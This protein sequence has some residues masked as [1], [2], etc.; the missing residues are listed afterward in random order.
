VWVKL[1]E[2]G[3][4]NGVWAVDTLITNRGKHSVTLPKLTPGEYLLRPEII[5]LHEGNRVG[6]AQFYMECVQ[7]KVTGSGSVSLPAGV[8]I[9]GTYTAQDPGVLFDIYNSFSSYPIPGPKVW[10]G[11]SGSGAAPAPV[12]SKA[13]APA[14]SVAAVATSAPA[15]TPKPVTSAPAAAPKPTTFVTLVKSVTRT[16]APAATAPAGNT[17]GA[18]EKY[19]RCGGQGYTGSTI[20]ADGWTCKVQNPWYSQCLSA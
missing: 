14:S 18:V 4:S 19:G 8:A 7:I 2:E 6:G 20:C 9:P 12:S 17:S 5:A 10:N 16:V 11:A 3:Y 15:A 1:A 13:P